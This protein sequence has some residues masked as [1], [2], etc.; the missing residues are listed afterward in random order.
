MPC[1]TKSPILLNRNNSLVKAMIFDC[2][3]K[4]LHSGLKDTLNE[5]RCNFW[6]T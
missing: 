3:R 2:G 5:L 4:V 1:E 6:V